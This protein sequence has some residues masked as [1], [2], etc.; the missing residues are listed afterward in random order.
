MIVEIG[1]DGRSLCL[2]GLH[3]NGY[4]AEIKILCRIG[5]ITEMELPSLIQRNMLP[6]RLRSRT[7]PSQNEQKSG[8][9]FLLKRFQSDRFYSDQFAK[10]FKAAVG[11]PVSS[12]APNPYPCQPL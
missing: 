1:S 11:L 6:R 8:Q 5:R 3:E 9:Y 10:A 4:R 7:K 12:K 2:A